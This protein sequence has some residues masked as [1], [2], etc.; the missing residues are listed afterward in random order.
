MTSKRLGAL[1]R[2]VPPA[3][4]SIVAEPPA[5]VTLPAI[6]AAVA[7]EPSPPLPAAPRAGK[8][9][10]GLEPE[11]PLQVLIP[12]SIRKRFGVMA[13]EEGV[14]LRALTLRAIRGLG[15]PVT[16]AQIKGKRGH[17]NS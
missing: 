6:A 15:V 1:L 7:P 16:D 8:P 14:S 17:K 5:Q 4:A 13:A 9:V 11:V 3:T 2:S 12:E 10:S